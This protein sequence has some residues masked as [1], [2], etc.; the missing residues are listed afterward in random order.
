[1]QKLY[2]CE[3]CGECF[4][5]ETAALRCEERHKAEYERRAK[6]KEE[7]SKRTEEIYEANR[8]IEELVRDFIQDYG[9]PCVIG[10]RLH[11]GNM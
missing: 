9:D 7:K 3:V 8:R 4:N 6:L 1:M 5:N 11:I 10:R 2:K